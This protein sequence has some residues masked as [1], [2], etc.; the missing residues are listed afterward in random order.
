MRATWLPP[1][2]Y[3]S[4]VGPTGLILFPAPTENMGKGKKERRGGG[5]VVAGGETKR[6]K[7]GES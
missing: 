3:Y 1:I 7:I 6:E 5:S 2:G 4:Q